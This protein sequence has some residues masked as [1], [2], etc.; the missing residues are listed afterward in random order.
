MHAAKIPPHL[1]KWNLFC[2]LKRLPNCP[3]LYQVILLPVS[4]SK[5]QYHPYLSP[6]DTMQ[7]CSDTT[8]QSCHLSLTA[9][10]TWPPLATLVVYWSPIVWCFYWYPPLGDPFTPSLCVNHAL[11]SS[12]RAPEKKSLFSSGQAPKK[13]SLFYI[14]G[15]PKNA[16]LY[17]QRCT[18]HHQRNL[19]F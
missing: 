6:I 5:Y 10:N 11:F 1:W 2:S 9:E 8:Y 16:G 14:G 4:S 12:G 3:Y 15:A 17:H 13:K 7:L 19:P 18:F